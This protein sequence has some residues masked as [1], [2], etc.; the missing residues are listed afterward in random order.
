M[1]YFSD[2]NLIRYYTECIDDASQQQPEIRAL[3]TDS[4]ADE[5]D[6]TPESFATIAE[7]FRIALLTGILQPDEIRRW[8]DQLIAELPEAPGELVEISWSKD[9][10]M[11]MNA[12]ESIQGER[13]KK[14]AGKCLLGLVRENLPKSAL[15][16]AAAQAMYIVQLA[17]LGNELYLKFDAVHEGLSLAYNGIVGTVG[18]YR[19]ELVSLLAKFP[20]ICLSKMLPDTVKSR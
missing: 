2:L 4:I 8:A 16:E 9:L 5:G 19:A 7:Y 10:P 1:K 15:M 20:S 14:L 12:L 17:D 6:V 11:L 18:P 3:P 13:D